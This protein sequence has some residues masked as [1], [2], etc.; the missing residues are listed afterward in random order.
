MATET[1]ERVKSEDPEKLRE[2]LVRL[3]KRRIL[4]DRRNGKERD[5]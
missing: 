1:A 3:L 5:E 4:A 2:A